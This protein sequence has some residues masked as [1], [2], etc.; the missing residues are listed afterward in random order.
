MN[1]EVQEHFYEKLQEGEN[2][3]LCQ[4]IRFNQIKE[5]IIFVEQTNLSLEKSIFETSRL[6]IIKYM[7]IQGVKLN[8]PICF[9]AIHSGNAEQIQ[10]LEEN[11]VFQTPLCDC[12]EVLKELNQIPS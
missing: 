3:Y 12:K 4:L 1:N 7:E 5:F 9:Y 2:D 11:H 10:Y 8:S 6:L